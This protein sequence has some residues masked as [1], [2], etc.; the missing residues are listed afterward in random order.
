MD[1]KLN[2][3][4]NLFGGLTALIFVLLLSSCS[5]QKKL[6][7]NYK[8]LDIFSEVEKTAI[9]NGSQNT[10]M[11]VLKIDNEKD[12]SILTSSSQI[13]ALEV[14][15]PLLKYFTE[16]LYHTVT[17]SISLGVGIAAPQVGILK[18][19]IW[20]QRFDKEGDPFELYINPRIIQ[21]SKMKQ[22][23]RE[24][25]LS[26]PDRMDV[27]E[28]R[29]YAILIEYQTLANTLH[30]EM[31]EGFTSVIFQ[32]EIDHLNGIIYIDRIKE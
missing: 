32:H 16:R 22:S 10:P 21:Y 17:D 18:Q 19:I 27:L 24:G 6:I 2:K 12:L 4:N 31:V 1:I 20:V 25:C 23:Y 9:K 28:T 29:S 30:V 5:S 11:R 26:V 7:H 14:E 3:K 8:V 15:D 13:V